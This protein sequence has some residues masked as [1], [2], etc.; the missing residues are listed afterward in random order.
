[1]QKKRS[2]SSPKHSH[3]IVTMSGEFNLFE[4]TFKRIKNIFFSSALLL[5]I[6]KT[7]KTSFKKTCSFQKIYAARSKTFPVKVVVEKRTQMC[8]KNHLQLQHKLV[9]PKTSPN[10][11]AV[12]KTFMADEFCQQHHSSSHSR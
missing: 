2:A 12:Q 6:A 5:Q 7:S 8:L 9:K 1:M 11:F 4:F 3:Q 10:S